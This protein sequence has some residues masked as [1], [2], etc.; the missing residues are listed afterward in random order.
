MS[1][2]I[3]RE[4][5]KDAVINVVGRE[6]IARYLDEMS[7]HFCTKDNDYYDALMDAED[8]IDDLPSAD[9]APV[10]HGH[11]EDV[12]RMQMHDLHGVLTWGNSFKCTECQ[13]KTFAVEG[14]MSQYNYCPN[15]GARMDGESDE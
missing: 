12:D 5:A 2:Y 8:A 7:K 13:F 6:S 15:C 4:D 11:W 1:D 10:R 9:V 14:H 3:K